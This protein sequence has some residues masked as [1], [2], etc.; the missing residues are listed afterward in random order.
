M[1]AVD[2]N[3]YG[4]VA[5]VVF[6]EAF[7]SA[8]VRVVGAAIEFKRFEPFEERFSA[9]VGDLGFQPFAHF[10]YF[11][12]AHLGV[13]EESTC[14]YSFKLGALSDNRGFGVFFVDF[15]QLG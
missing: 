3:L 14:G 5:C 2:E 10:F 8:Y 12:A 4:F 7:K 11:I 13:F 15:G 1:L 9:C 6:A